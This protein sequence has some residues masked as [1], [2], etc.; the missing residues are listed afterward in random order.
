MW[1]RKQYVETKMEVVGQKYEE[2]VKD[3]A[4]V[5]SLIGQGT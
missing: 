4:A 1:N 3:L 2:E 5:I